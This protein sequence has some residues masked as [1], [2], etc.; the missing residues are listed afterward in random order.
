MQ[1]LET[2]TNIYIYIYIYICY[3]VGKVEGRGADDGFD[4]PFKAKAISNL[5]KRRIHRKI[6]YAV[7]LN[8]KRDFKE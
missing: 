8:N 5:K 3:H 4:G 7:E 2:Y 1:G 6:N